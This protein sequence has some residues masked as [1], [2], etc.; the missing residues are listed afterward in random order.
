MYETVIVNASSKSSG[1]H[2]NM[3]SVGSRVTW[4]PRVQKSCG[5][6]WL[7][8]LRGYQDISSDH[9][10]TFNGSN[11]FTWVKFFTYV[12]FFCEGQFFLGGSKDFV[13]IKN[14]SASQ[15]FWQC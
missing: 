11:F 13:R 6:G 5:L 1:S 9:G 8:E 4:L 12:D 14:F 3:G 2:A 10:S 7:Y 15:I